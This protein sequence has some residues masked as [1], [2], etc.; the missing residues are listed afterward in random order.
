LLILPA[1][2]ALS[3]VFSPGNPVLPSASLPRWLGLDDGRGPIL[4]R[5]FRTL[6]DDPK[7]LTFLQTQRGSARF[8]AATPTALLAA[9]LIIRS[10]QPA[11]AFGGYLGNDPVMSVDDFAERV[12]RGEVRYAILGLARRP[13]DFDAWVR[14]HGVQV[15]PAL[16]RSLP[17]EP[18][19]AIAL[20]E[21][22][23]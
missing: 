18:R 9:P 23:R 17:P 3:P 10:G 22:K 2:W 8:L 7:L 19:R 21:L 13:A 5:R 12:K 14:A 11:L 4:S 6:T 15:D 20:Y 16:W 1:A